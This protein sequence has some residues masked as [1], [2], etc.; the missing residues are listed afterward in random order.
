MGYNFSENDRDQN[1]GGELLPGKA[2]NVVAPGE[3]Q[4][5]GPLDLE[6]AIMLAPLATASSISLTSADFTELSIAV[7]RAGKALRFQARG[8]SMSPLVRD[9]DFVLVQPVQP[10]TLR[11]G[12]V[13]LCSSGPGRVVVHRV[14]GRTVRPD[15]ISFIVQGDRATRPDGLVPAAQVH[16]RVATVERAGARIDLDGPAVRWLGRLAAFGSRSALGRGR[17]Y[18]LAGRLLRR[19]PG[20]SPYLT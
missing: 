19:L 12:D 15:G 11:F 13:V 4:G 16:G 5:P 3:E 2:K 7:L 17:P 10:G 18:R 14:V 20:L 8:S 9:G 1:A 6:Y